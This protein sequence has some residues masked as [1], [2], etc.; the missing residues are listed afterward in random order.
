MHQTY[1]LTPPHPPP[2]SHTH[3]STITSILSSKI[4]SLNQTWSLKGSSL[5]P[6]LYCLI[7]QFL[8]NLPVGFLCVQHRFNV[9]FTISNSFSALLKSYIIQFASLTCYFTG[10]IILP[11]CI[12]T[13]YTYMCVC[14]QICLSFSYTS[15]DLC[16]QNHHEGAL[17]PWSWTA[18]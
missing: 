15:S 2:L 7:H 16:P 9:K 12:P 11:I 4:Y 17:T 3:T 14:F 10:V 13:V 5:P 8:L 18:L 6:L 1:Y